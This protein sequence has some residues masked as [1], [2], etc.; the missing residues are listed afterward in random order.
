MVANVSGQI[1]LGDR[2][3]VYYNSLIVSS[4]K[5]SCEKHSKIDT[6]SFHLT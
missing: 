6:V 4:W 2:L 5:R 1:G 3:S